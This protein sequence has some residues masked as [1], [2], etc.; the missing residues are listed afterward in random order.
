MISIG[1]L[2]CP[3]TITFYDRLR[4]VGYTDI[5]YYNFQMALV[6]TNN[7]RNRFQALIKRTEDTFLLSI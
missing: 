6:A 7:L 4:R 3:S 2:D 1:K 5:I